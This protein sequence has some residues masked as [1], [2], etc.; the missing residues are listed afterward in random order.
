[1]FKS[2]Q[3]CD[4]KCYRDY[5]SLNSATEPGVFMNSDIE[6]ANGTKNS[7]LFYNDLPS[8][9]VIVIRIYK[10]LVWAIFRPVLWRIYIV[11]FM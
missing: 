2:L 5:Y 1:M 9:S 8:L 3:F 11:F 4:E 6:T 7:L 10:L